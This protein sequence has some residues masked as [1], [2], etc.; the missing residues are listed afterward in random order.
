MSFSLLITSVT[1]ALD[2]EG[3]R[4]KI[5]RECMICELLDKRTKVIPKLNHVE[6]ILDI[7]Q[8]KYVIEEVLSILVYVYTLQNHAIDP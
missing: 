1:T 7:S 4:A 2:H 8:S 3:K 5:V 6:H